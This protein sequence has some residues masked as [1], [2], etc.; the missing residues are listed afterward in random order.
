MKIESA[1]Y[2]R[3][4]SIFKNV[5]LIQTVRKHRI[6]KHALQIYLIFSQPYLYQHHL[7]YPRKDASVHTSKSAQV[8]KPAEVWKQR[9]SFTERADG[10]L[11]WFGVLFLLLSFTLFTYLLTRALGLKEAGDSMYWRSALSVQSGVTLPKEITVLQTTRVNYVGLNIQNML[12]V[13]CH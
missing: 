1:L 9:L 4:Q 12:K 8:G 10:I 5:E 13:H 2:W 3:I 11:V 7:G 6:N